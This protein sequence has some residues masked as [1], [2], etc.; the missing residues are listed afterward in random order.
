MIRILQQNNK[1]VKVLFGV[2][3]GL[4]VVT[5]VI[6]LVPGIFD[7]VGGSS[8]PNTYAT[9]HETGFFGRIFGE[10][11]TISQTDVARLAQQQVQRQGLPAMYAQFMMPQ[12][13]QALVQRKILQIEADR[14]HLQVTDADLVK[15]L[16]EGQLGQ[17]LFPGGKYIGDDAYMNF[18]QNQLGMTRSQ[19]EELIKA[20]MEVDRLHELI[21]GGVTV[22][23]NDVRESY[24]K[25]GT[26]VKFD[27][28]VISSADIGNSLNP[29]DAD[30]QAFFKA[31]AARYATAVPETRKIAYFSFGIDDLP[32]GPPKVSDAQ[33]QAYYNA[34]LADYQVKDQV[35]A[36]HILIAVPAGSDAKTDEA[37]KAKAQGILDQLHKGADF[38]AL[39]KA[40]S[41]DPGSKAQGGEL[42]WFTKEKMV[43]AF[44]QAAFALEPGQI[45]GLVKTSF[46][47]HIIQV[48]EKQTAHTKSLAEVRDQIVPV[49]QQQMLGQAEQNYANTLTAEAKKNGLDKT[50]QAHG[51]HVVTTD[52]V[53]KDGVIAGVADGTG[54]LSGAFS[55]AKGAAPAS[56]STGDGYAV[57]QVAD[58]K[59]AH[60]PTFDEWKS[61]IL[62]D[63]RDQHVP[64]MLSAQLNKLDQLAKQLGDLHKAAAQLNIPVKTSD[65]V[66]KD[67]QV[68]DVG[69]MAGPA[70]AAFS[71][72]KGGISGPLN[73]GQSGIVLQVVDKQEPSPEDI[74][75][76]FEQTKEQMLQDK[77]EEVFRVYLGTLA[78]KYQKAGAIRMKAKAP[79]GLPLS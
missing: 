47:Y 32:G 20:D 22:S 13:G 2:I 38:A 49:L 55:E 37:A 76:N 5:M 28:A 68:P 24:R 17:I 63:Y 30:L 66:G 56:A 7:N 10:T 1:A 6:T 58:V 23:D 67:G 59:P 18:V 72:P 29:S 74:A 50:A 27:Y 3:I 79:A 51:L 46:G 40:D 77:Q 21:T 8:D 42:G 44:S 41:D 31:N 64:E 78:Q 43:P 54:I 53:A 16:H 33:I 12:A 48:E 34:H 75:K 69:S 71:L 36:R 14:M 45:S 61:H 60:A 35:R 39:A 73:T 9:V 57:Y 4:A 11:E 15:E 25:S 65:L 26:K 70:S 52:Y 19:F 62:S